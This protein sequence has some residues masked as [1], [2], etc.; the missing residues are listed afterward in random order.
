[1]P[2]KMNYPYNYDHDV[3]KEKA[4]KVKIAEE[5]KNSCRNSDY[6][7]NEQLDEP[8]KIQLSNPVHNPPF[9]NWGVH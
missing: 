6:C 4:E 1:M 7:D 3:K 5:F 9:N 8:E 2:P